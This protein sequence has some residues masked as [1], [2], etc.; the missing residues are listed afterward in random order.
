MKR[1]LKRWWYILFNDGCQDVTPNG[2]FRVL[3]LT[4]EESMR[5]NYD[6]AKNWAKMFGGTVIDAF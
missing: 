3:Y 2:K 6:G 4:G 1:R 5:F